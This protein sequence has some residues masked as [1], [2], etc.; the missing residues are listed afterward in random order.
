MK[1]ERINTIKLIKPSNEY[2]EQIVEYCAEFYADGGKA[3]SDSGGKIQGM[4]HI[5]NFDSPFGWI[6][7]CRLYEEY[8]TIPNKEHVTATQYLTVR[9]S[10]NMLVG[11]IQLRHQLIGDELRKF[12]GHI[13]YSIRP[14]ER[15]KGY[16]KEQLRLC[17]EKAREYG[18]DQVLLCCANTNTASRQTILANGGKY[19]S[20]ILGEESG[21]YVERYWIRL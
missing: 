14:S 17:L 12:S 18:L 1:T 15:R 10:D 5:Q 19:E 4:A 13:G 6:E 2:V 11:A 20:T 3:L 21:L 16:A 8:D 9:E 7:N